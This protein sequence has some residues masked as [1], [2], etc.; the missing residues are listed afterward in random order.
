M[1]WIDIKVKDLKTQIN[2]QCVTDAKI[3]VEVKYEPDYEPHPGC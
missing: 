1:Q 3:E 2:D